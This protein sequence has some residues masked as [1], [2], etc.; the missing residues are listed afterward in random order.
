MS[1]ENWMATSVIAELKVKFTRTIFLFGKEEC[2]G[3]GR[4]I[5]PNE[6]FIGLVARYLQMIENNTP[7]LDD[8]LWKLHAQ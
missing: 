4:K 3:N 6:K 8:F 1:T 7:Y 5:S 2:L